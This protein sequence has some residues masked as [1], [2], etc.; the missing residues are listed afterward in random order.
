[1]S[2]NQKNNKKNPSKQMAFSHPTKKPNQI[3][4]QI[5][6]SYPT[7]NQHKSQNKNSLFSS[8]QKPNPPPKTNGPF[9]IQ[10]KTKSPQNK[11]PLLI[12]PK[13]KSPQKQMAFTHPT[14]KNKSSPK[15]EKAMA[16]IHTYIIMVSMDSLTFGL[17]IY[18]CFK[19]GTLL[20]AN[21]HLLATT[22]R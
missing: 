12:Q 2:S 3:P 16:H 7:K 20:W 8:N 10:P 14:K 19:F 15:K 9:L 4:K 21:F 11:W 17:T 5:A 13:T 22:K 18:S 1:L 6:F